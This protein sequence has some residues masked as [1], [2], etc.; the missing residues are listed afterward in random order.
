M[1]PQHTTV[2]QVKQGIKELEYQMTTRTL[3]AT[4]EAKMIREISNL[5]KSIPSAERLA[6]LDP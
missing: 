1:H 4:Q 3:N 5:K 6:E 2:E